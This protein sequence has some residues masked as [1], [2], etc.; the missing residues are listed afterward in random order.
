MKK[1]ALAAIAAVLLSAAPA[2]AEGEDLHIQI[3]NN[4]STSLTELYVSHVGTNSW[5]ENILSEEAEAGATQPVDIEDGR[6]TCSY[7]IKAVF[8]DGGTAEFRNQNL[9]TTSTFIVHE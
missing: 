4:T 8:E 9:C 6:D 5:E 7:D 2:L 1:F 3:K